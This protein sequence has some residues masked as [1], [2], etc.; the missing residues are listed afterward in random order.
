M[1]VPVPRLDDRDFDALVGELRARIPVMTP[2]WTDVGP[3]DPGRTLLELM[4]F[5]AENVLYRFN[6]LPEA[7]WAQLL[8]LL[9]VPL[10]PAVPASGLV[11]LGVADPGSV[12]GTV[13][14][15]TTIRAGA[16]AFETLDDVTVLPLRAQAVI[17]R[18]SAAPIDADLLAEADATLDALGAGA[19]E[20]RYYAVRGLPADPRLAQTDPLPVGEA[21]DGALWVALRADSAELRTALLTPGGSRA[22]TGRTVSLGVWVDAAPSEMAAAEACPGWLGHSAVR[23]QISWVTSTTTVAPDESPVFAPVEVVGDLTGGLRQT[24]TVQLKFPATLSTLGVPV[25]PAEAAGGGDYPPVVDDPE[26][27]VCWLR[28]RPVGGAPGIPSLGWVDVN[29]TRVVQA[30]TAEAEYLGT[31]TG[32]PDQV[33]PLAHRQLQ[34]DLLALTVDVEEEP[35]RWVTWTRVTNL[36]DGHRND[37]HWSLDAEAGHVRFGDTVRGRAPQFGQRIRVRPY[38]Y[39]GGLAGNLQAGALNVVETPVPVTMRNPLPTIGGVDAESV[40]EGLDRVP[41][42]LPP[43]RSGGVE[44]A[45]DFAELAEGTPGAEVIRA[46]CLPRFDPRT[47]ATEAAGVVAVVDMAAGRAGTPGGAGPDPRPDRAGVPVPGRATT[48]HHRAVHRA[49]GVSQGRGIAGR[50]HPPRL[51]FRRGPALVGTGTSASTSPRAPVRAR[52]PRLAA[53]PPGVRA[54]TGGGGAPGRGHR[55]RRRAARRRSR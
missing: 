36:A 47:K 41:G 2:E 23:G 5:L 3:A 51:L 6:Q 10:R 28:A 17:K 19:A 45:T 13:A 9:D 26:T 55:I 11:S 22:L 37:R 38:R 39:G 29:A 16:V 34:P 27:V 32:N 18:A 53:R 21:V 44:P 43:A 52:G 49:T 20:P 40:G 48:R 50:H 4:A 46:E 24:G 31:G 8:R 33:Y 15:A 12:A 7:A 35:E 42:E 25:P 30:V 54:R 1:P 14:S